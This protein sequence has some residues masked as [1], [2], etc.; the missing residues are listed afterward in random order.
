MYKKYNELY[1][2]LPKTIN[3]YKEKLKKNKKSVDDIFFDNSVFLFQVFDSASIPYFLTADSKTTISLNA[4]VTGGRTNNERYKEYFLDYAA[5]VDLESCYGTGLNEFKLP[6]GLPTI[7]AKAPNENFLTL[8]EFLK[9]YEFDF[10]PNLWKI[11]VSGEL[12]F[13]QDLIFSRAITPASANNFNKK[14]NIYDGDFDNL[15]MLTSKLVLLRHKRVNGV[16]THDIL[17]ILRK[18]CSKL[19]MRDILNLKVQT[20]VFLKK[21]DKVDNVKEW[22]TSVLNDKNSM[23]FDVQ[24]QALSDK[25]TRKWFGYL[26]KNFIQPLLEKRKEFKEKM[27]TTK[28]KLQK[29]ELNAKQTNIKSMINTLYGVFASQYF[30]VGNSILADNITAKARTYVWLLIKSLNC[31]MCIT[32]GSTYGLNEVFF[33]NKKGKKPSLKTLSNLETLEK[34][35]SIKKLPLGGISKFQNYRGDFYSLNLDFLVTQHITNF[36]DVYNIKF[37]Y[38]IEHKPEHLAIKTGFMEKG[39][40]ALKTYDKEEKNWSKCV[41]KTRGQK[42]YT[43]GKRNPYF[44]FFQNILDGID[45]L[46]Q[47]L[48]YEHETLFFKRRVVV[49]N[50]HF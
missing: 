13:E 16:I 44:V 43:N 25:R 20:A 49:F 30:R 40:Y 37:A 4:L 23:R 26:L 27:K 21:S 12:G 22:S 1:S 29:G 6:V 2:N 50:L 46:P 19:E 36:W 8:R 38:C 17:E 7:V 24:I 34:H 35:R 48:D 33:L 45:V 18:I 39:N 47:F 42:E 14:Q 31:N 5:D 32:D 3:E 10:Y 11:V 15:N 28:N 41:F 9:L